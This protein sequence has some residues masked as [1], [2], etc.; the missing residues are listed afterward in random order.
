MK[1][2]RSARGPGFDEAMIALHAQDVLGVDESP[3][4]VVDN[5]DGDGL[6]RQRYELRVDDCRPLR[7]RPLTGPLG[8]S[9]PATQAKDSQF[10][11][12]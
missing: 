6:P 4:N 7:R 3:V 8:E 1:A 10:R 9:S 5:L 2:S 12:R 11:R